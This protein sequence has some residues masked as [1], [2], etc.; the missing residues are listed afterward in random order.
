VASADENKTGPAFARPVLFVLLSIHVGMNLVDGTR[1]GI[2][3][4]MSNIT[5]EKSTATQLNKTKL[6]S[7]DIERA[8]LLLFTM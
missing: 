4:H 7:I 3:C 5:L 2:Q 1:S 8:Q 6:T